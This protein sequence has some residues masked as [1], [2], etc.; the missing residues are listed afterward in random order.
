MKTDTYKKP[1]NREQTF[2]GSIF[3]FILGILIFCF[4]I[5]FLFFNER[6]YLKE[7]LLIEKAYKLCIEINKDEELVNI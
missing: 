7:K 3:D 6:R 2:S 1:T 5:P 4:S